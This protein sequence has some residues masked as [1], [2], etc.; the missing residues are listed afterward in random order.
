LL[1]PSSKE[2]PTE[3]H[4]LEFL[5]GKE[6]YQCRKMQDGLYQSS[7]QDPLLLCK[8]NQQGIF[9]TIK[10]DKKFFQNEN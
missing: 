3:A 8:S 6:W 5:F 10:N 1:K 2:S 4:F 9:G 7:N